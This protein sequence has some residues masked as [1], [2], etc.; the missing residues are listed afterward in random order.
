LH[1]LIT[2]TTT[3]DAADC[4][5]SDSDDEDEDDATSSSVNY[6]TPRLKFPARI[7]GLSSVFAEFGLAYLPLLSSPTQTSPFQTDLNN[8][9]SLLVTVSTLPSQFPSSQAAQKLGT[10]PLSFWWEVSER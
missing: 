1:Q 10:I 4:D 8:L 2:V 9:I 6:N 3:K 5:E 7:R